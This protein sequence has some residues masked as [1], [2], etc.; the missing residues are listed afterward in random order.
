MRSD[1]R[2]DQIWLSRDS[3]LDKVAGRFGLLK[4]YPNPYVCT[5]PMF[6]FKD[7]S[8]NYIRIA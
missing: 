1:E 6:G 4:A 8:S 5:Q 2:C 7:R 3:R